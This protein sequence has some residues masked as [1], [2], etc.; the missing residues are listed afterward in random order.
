MRSLLFSFVETLTAPSVI[1]PLPL[2]G[3]PIVRKLLLSV[4]TNPCWKKP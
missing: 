3:E 4:K 2:L 1:S